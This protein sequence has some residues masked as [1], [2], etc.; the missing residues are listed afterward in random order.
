MLWKKTRVTGT[1]NF[2]DKYIISRKR[3]HSDRFLLNTPDNLLTEI[4]EIRYILQ[5]EK[6]RWKH[7]EIVT[8]SKLFI[9]YFGIKHGSQDGDTAS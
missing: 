3:K 7:V 1:Q 8:K 2:W 6:K 4:S 5:D 9:A